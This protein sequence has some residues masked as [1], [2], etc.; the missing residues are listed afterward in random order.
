MLL[1]V[2]LYAAA[3]QC[4]GSLIAAGM[5]FSFASRRKRIQRMVD[6]ISYG[7]TIIALGTGVFSLH[8]YDQ[9][10]AENSARSMQLRKS[11]SDASKHAWAYSALCLS[12]WQEPGYLGE[13]RREDCRKLEGFMRD[14]KV[15]NKSVISL[16]NYSLDFNTPESQPLESLNLKLLAMPPDP[17]L[18]STK[19]MQEFVGEVARDYA[20]LNNAFVDYKAQQGGKPDALEG[21]Y[22]ALAIPLLAFAFGL[23]VS[24]RGLDLLYGLAVLNDLRLCPTLGKRVKFAPSRYKFRPDFSSFF[25]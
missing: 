25:S 20:A 8:R 22:L 14:N 5:W 23:G 3:A 16:G 9:R 19:E 15:E 11:H 1:S 2:S 12:S 21:G 13:L 24:R 18:F 17:S 6:L 7:L 4:S 10:A